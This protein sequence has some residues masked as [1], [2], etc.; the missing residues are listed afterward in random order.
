[1]FEETE[2]AQNALPLSSRKKACMRQ[3]RIATI[4]TGL[5]I[6]G[7]PC[8]SAKD[9]IFGFQDPR[10]IEFHGLMFEDVRQYWKDLANE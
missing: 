3:C 9:C 5:E 4:K 7:C 2:L 8:D 1:M 6:G 10:G